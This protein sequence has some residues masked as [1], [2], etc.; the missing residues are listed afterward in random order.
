LSAFERE[1]GINQFETKLIPVLPFCAT[2][3]GLYIQKHQGDQLTMI[4]IDRVHRWT[5]TASAWRG[6]RLVTWYFCLY[7]LTAA[8]W[9]SSWWW[10]TE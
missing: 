8:A 4:Y 10:H 3:I 2:C 5:A 7:N 9:A 6:A 1:K